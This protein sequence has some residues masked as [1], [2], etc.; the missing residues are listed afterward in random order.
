MEAAGALARRREAQAVH[1]V[2][3]HALAA[4][5]ERLGE[6]GEVEELVATLAAQTAE[7]TLAAS[8]AGA[9]IASQVLSGSLGG[10]GDGRVTR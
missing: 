2:R 10:G 8:Q 5:L 1:L 7:G 4:L 9:Q 6:E 3:E